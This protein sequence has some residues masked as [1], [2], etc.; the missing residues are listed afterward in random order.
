MAVIEAIALTGLKTLTSSLI[1]KFSD[2]GWNKVAEEYN[3]SFSHEDLV[4]FCMACD[5]Y[6]NIRTLY[7]SQKDVFIDDV[8]VPLFMSPSNDLDSQY[9]I[10]NLNFYSEGI[11]NIIGRAGQGKSTFLRKM[12]LNELQHGSTIP[13]FFELKYINTDESLVLQLSKWFSRHNL[14]ISEKGIGRLLKY[15]YLKIFLDAFDEIEPSKQGSALEI[16]KDLSRL[17]PKVTIIVTSRPDT[18]ITTE[19]FISNYNVLSLSAENVRK[20]FLNISENNVQRTDEAIEQLEKNPQIFEIAKTPILS[21]LLFITYRTWSKIPD[22]LADF[23]KKIFITLLTHHDTLKPGKK[24]DRGINIPLNDHKIEDVFSVFCFTTFS[25]GVTSFSTREASEFMEKSLE[26]ECHDDICPED[27]VDTIKKCTGIISNDGYDQL[28]FS[29]KSLQEYYTASYIAGQKIHDIRNF[30]SAVKVY[31]QEN[32]YDAVLK[33]LSSLDRENY[34]RYYYIPCFKEMFEVSSVKPEIDYASMKLWMGKVIGAVEI[35]FSSFHKSIISSENNKSREL[36]I[37]FRFRVNENMS[38][39]FYRKIM[40]DLMLSLIKSGIYLEY[41]KE[42]SNELKESF[43]TN[44]EVSVSLADLLDSVDTEKSDRFLDLLEI[45]FGEDIS[46]P[47]KELMKFYKKK[48]K[49]S[50]LNQVFKK[51]EPA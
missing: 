11:T 23:Y 4:R 10:S 12:L 6:V 28:C 17:Y 5:E 18:I 31:S 2:L 26:S 22:N 35:P 33:F 51:E 42:N 14:N 20:L 46:T 44:R 15:G 16:I 47:H 27:V 13:V 21:I 36:S 9:E 41:I 48:S 19:P 30:Y 3:A 34:I 1:K 32:K 37:G 45:A 49:P 24:I 43:K 50:L 25:E 7:S 8:Y 29:H 40:S 39:F 38:S